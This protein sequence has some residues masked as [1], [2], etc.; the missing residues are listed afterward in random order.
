MIRELNVLTFLKNCE[1]CLMFS[2]NCDMIVIS[3]PPTWAI[4]IK[5][6]G[7]KYVQV[8][9]SELYLNSDSMADASITHMHVCTPPTH[10]HHIK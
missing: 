6:N 5:R 4:Q 7:K 8:S 9:S 10:K 3:Y 1:K 2:V